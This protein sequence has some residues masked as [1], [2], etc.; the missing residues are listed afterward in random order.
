MSGIVF[1]CIRFTYLRNERQHVMARDCEEFAYSIAVKLPFHAFL[2]TPE[3]A[4]ENLN[5]QSTRL[6]REIFL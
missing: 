1:F 6:D 4:K 5:V 3:V 2:E